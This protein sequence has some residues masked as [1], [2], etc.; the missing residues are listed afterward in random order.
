MIGL[1]GSVRVNGVEPVAMRWVTGPF[2][3]FGQLGGIC[4]ASLDGMN[5]CFHP[6]RVQENVMGGV[7]N[8]MVDS[9]NSVCT[10]L[11]QGLSERVAG[12]RQAAG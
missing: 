9:P 7:R 8:G 4:I 1:L 2:Q 6:Q 12:C 10:V 5:V 3:H 11:R